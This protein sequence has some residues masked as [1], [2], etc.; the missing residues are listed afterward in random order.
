MN[1]LKKVYIYMYIYI[2]IF[3]KVY[4]KKKNIYIFFKKNIYK[5]LNK[6]PPNDSIG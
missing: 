6:W 3:E 2:Y 4:L 1:L 5:D